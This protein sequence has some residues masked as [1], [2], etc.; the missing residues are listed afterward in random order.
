[1]RYRQNTKVDILYGPPVNR[2][3]KTISIPSRELIK[4]AEICH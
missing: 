3:T 2:T 1:M 4:I